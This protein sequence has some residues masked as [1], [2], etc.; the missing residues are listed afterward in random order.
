MAAEGDARRGEYRAEFKAANEAAARESDRQGDTGALVARAELRA[1]NAELSKP[2]QSAQTRDALLAQREVLQKRLFAPEGAAPVLQPPADDPV[3]KLAAKT[4]PWSPQDRAK[5]DA[6]GYAGIDWP[7]APEGTTWSPALDAIG[8]QLVGRGIAPAVI[9]RWVA[10]GLALRDQEPATDMTPPLDENLVRDA[11]FA[12]EAYVPDP[13]LGGEGSKFLEETRLGDDF[14]FI[15]ELAVLGKPLRALLTKA[16]GARR[17]LAGVN[18]G[19]PTH[20]RL[21]ETIRDAYKRVYGG[22]P[23][24]IRGARRP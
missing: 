16:R 2:L 13:A 4:E 10:R 18:P 1:L 9:E 11:Q 8:S 7:A 14:E 20:T 22:A 15:R 5:L 12:L 17:A 24:P 23:L 21:S 6:V 19:T 3:A